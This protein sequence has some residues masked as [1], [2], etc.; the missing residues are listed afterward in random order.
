MEEEK[1]NTTAYQR[2]S[3]GRFVP[4]N[5]SSWQPGQSGNP[6][7]SPKKGES[8]TMEQ[9][10]ML[11]Q[12]CPYDAKERTWL[13]YLCEKGLIQ[14]SEKPEAMRDFK[15]RT[16]GKAPDVLTIT[17]DSKITFNVKYEGKESETDVPT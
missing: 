2:D 10:E 11:N 13:E 8:I 12:P 15:D 16:E 3:R 9:R 14:I 1:N 4:G 5:P 7:G 6:A 17:P